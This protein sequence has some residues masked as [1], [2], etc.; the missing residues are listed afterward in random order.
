MAGMF[1]LD[2]KT[3]IVTGAAGLYG[4][5]IATALA[6]ANASVAAV[7]RSG[8]SARIVAS[9]LEAAGGVAAA[10]TADLQ[11]RESLDRLCDDVLDRFGSIDVLV[12]NAVAR[13]GGDL[14]DT[15]GAA[16]VESGTVNA[17]G[18]FDLTKRCA[19]SMV[20]QASGSIINISS[21]YG[22]VGPDFTV[23]DGTDMTN[24][25]TYAYDKAGLIGLSRYF[26]TRLGRF[27]VRSNC[28]APGGL[29][30]NQDEKFVAAYEARTPLRRMADSD[31]IKGPVIFL[32]SDASK[33]VTGVTIPV[34]GG[35]TA[36]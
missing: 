1:S 8:D 27:G 2:G 26:A 20:Q 24:M 25:P 17:A 36:Q 4:R 16:F 3:A 14:F 12:N 6:A 15:T 33:Y 9:E 11:D 35:W 7:S 31:D 29:Y 10:F 23:Y 5:H 32:A 21:I 34:D 30:T 28:I 18:I 19:E 13:S 22:I